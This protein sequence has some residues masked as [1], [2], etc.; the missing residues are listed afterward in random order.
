MITTILKVTP[1][2]TGNITL[3][4]LILSLGCLCTKQ[5]QLNHHVQPPLV[6]NH[7]PYT[8]TYPNQTQ[9]LFPVTSF[10]S[11]PFI[12]GRAIFDRVL[13]RQ[14]SLQY[15]IDFHLS[16]KRPFDAWCDL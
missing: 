4:I 16:C 10:S 15:S 7:R 13:L 5:V 2:D 11:V 8:T 3:N 12:S 6:N 1:N 9:K 14:L